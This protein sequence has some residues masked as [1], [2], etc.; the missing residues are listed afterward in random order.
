MSCST[1]FHKAAIAVGLTTG[2]HGSSVMRQRCP[3]CSAWTG[4]GEMCGNPR[5]TTRVAGAEVD[6]EGDLIIRQGASLYDTVGEIEAIVHHAAERL[7]K[8]PPWDAISISYTTAGRNSGAW[9]PGTITARRSE[10]AKEPTSE[11]GVRLIDQNVTTQ[12]GAAG[13]GAQTPTERRYGMETYE[14]SIPVP[15]DGDASLDEIFEQCQERLEES[16]YLAGKEGDIAPTDAWIEIGPDSRGV[17][18]VCL[19]FVSD[20]P[21]D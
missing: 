19:D 11:F 9:R 2:V 10:V 14:V 7:G 15:E 13:T 4:K 5:C 6:G 17:A 16:D 8:S 1:A 3:E 20:R 12:L 21:F 18:M